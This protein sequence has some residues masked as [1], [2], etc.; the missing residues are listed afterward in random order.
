M[1][2][3]LR[4]RK[5]MIKMDIKEKIKAALIQEAD[6]SFGITSIAPTFTQSD[7]DILDEEKKGKKEEKSE[8]SSSESSSECS[9]EKALTEA[10]VEDIRLSARQLRTLMVASFAESL[11]NESIEDD[12]ELVSMGLLTEAMKITPKSKEYLKKFLPTLFAS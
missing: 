4:L 6:V 10:E 5:R 3:K 8:S 9:E 1:I 7:V 12:A 11:M 2:R